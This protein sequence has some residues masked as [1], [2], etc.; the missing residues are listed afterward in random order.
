MKDKLTIAALIIAGGWLFGNVWNL[1]LTAAR[2]EIAVSTMEGR[3]LRIT[4]LEQR[5][6]RLERR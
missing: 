5:V 4:A 1:S 2:L 6:G 3:D